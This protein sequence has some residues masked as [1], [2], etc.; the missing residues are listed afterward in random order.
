M[1]SGI[2]F[3]LRRQC[4]RLLH[5]RSPRQRATRRRRRRVRVLRAQP[6]RGHLA[7]HPIVERLLQL[8]AEELGRG[9]VGDGAGAA[10]QPPLPA[11]TLALTANDDAAN[12]LTKKPSDAPERMDEE[13]EY[14][15]SGMDPKSLVPCPSQHVLML[16]GA[17]CTPSIAAWYLMPSDTGGGGPGVG[18]KE[19]QTDA[20]VC[21]AWHLSADQVWYGS[22]FVDDK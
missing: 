17:S 7:E 12:M 5:R 16:R 18:A 14:K 15:Y 19:P 2:R 22:L 6:W 3:E 20:F 4:R 11:A 9:G 8:R 1:G 10:G 13:I 21:P